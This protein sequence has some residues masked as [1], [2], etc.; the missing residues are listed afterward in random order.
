MSHLHSTRII[1][2]N[3]NLFSSPHYHANSTEIVPLYKHHSKRQI[4][5][6]KQELLQQRQQQQQ[7]PS[8]SA[9]PQLKQPHEMPMP[10]IASNGPTLDNNNISINFILEVDGEKL[11]HPEAQVSGI[12]SNGKQTS[13]SLS[14]SSSSSSSTEL[15]VASQQ[16]A[17]YALAQEANKAASKLNDLLCRNFS[18]GIQHENGGIFTSPNY[19][20]PYPVNLICT[21]LIEGKQNFSILPFRQNI[22]IKSIFFD[23]NITKQHAAYVPYMIT[24]ISNSFRIGNYYLLHLLSSFNFMLKRFQ[25]V[26]MPWNV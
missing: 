20:N 12:S 3:T 1:T 16:M 15:S 2:T 19:P 4:V 9:L 5:E 6:S 26:M 18:I 24:H 21:K 22:L 23:I 25:T 10:L 11:P 14:P 8:L 13:S 17:A 7:Q